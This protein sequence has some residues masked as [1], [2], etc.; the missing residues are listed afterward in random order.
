MKKTTNLFDG[1]SWMDAPEYTAGT[2]KKVM[3]DQ[4]GVRT[5][6]LDLPAGFYME[7]HSHD[8]HEQFFVLKG[9]FFEG[10]E[11]CPEGT[12]RHFE[13]DEPHGPLE[14]RNP[15]LVLVVWNK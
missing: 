15:A 8:N 14:T 7:N 6:L 10:G 1:S 3:L 12:Y 13:P 11:P 9:E 5:V 2:K 4:M